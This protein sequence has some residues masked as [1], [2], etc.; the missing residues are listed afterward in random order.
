MVVSE[1]AY[2]EWKVGFWSESLN[3]ASRVSKFLL[4]IDLRKIFTNW[5]QD[6]AD[7][8]NALAPVLRLDDIRYVYSYLCLV[9]TSGLKCKVNNTGKY[10]GMPDKGVEVEVTPPPK[11]KK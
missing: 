6:E 9:V 11:K 7:Q 1:Y 2:T 3:L 5:D 4:L 10:I 8:A